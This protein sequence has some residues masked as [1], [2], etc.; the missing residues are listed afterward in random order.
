MAPIDGHIK[1]IRLFDLCQAE[2]GQSS[3]QLTEEEQQHLRMCVECR[4]VRAVFARQFSRKTAPQ[5]S[6][7]TRLMPQ[8][9]EVNKRFGVYRSLCCGAEI[10]IPEGVRFPDCPNHPKLT[11]QWKS[12]ADEKI[13]HVSE[14]FP[15]KKDPAA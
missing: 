9:G 3:F 14:I 4:Q 8:N 15:P 13:P 11:T 12:V 5:Q 7:G 2:F 10:V 6:E 1:A